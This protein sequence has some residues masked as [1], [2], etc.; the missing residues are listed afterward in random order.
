[1]SELPERKALKEILLKLKTKTLATEGHYRTYS[2]NVV[3]KFD[4]IQKL[5]TKRLEVEKKDSPPIVQ[6]KMNIEEIVYMVY[7]Q[8]REVIEHSQNV[9]DDLKLYIDSLEIYS[10]ELD[11]TLTDI[12][13]QARKAAEEQIKQQEEIMKRKSPESYIK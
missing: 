4:K 7:E 3:E 10:T 6:L 2:S 5:A 12:F 1:M 13:E 9:C 8:I 11:K